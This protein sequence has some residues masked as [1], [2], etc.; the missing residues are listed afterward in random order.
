MEL[1]IQDYISSFGI[2][3]SRGK[4]C[5]PD[6]FFPFEEAGLE[7]WNYLDAISNFF[8]FN[9]EERYLRIAHVNKQGE[10]KSFKKIERPPIDR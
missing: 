8:P 5:S 10:V 1:K 9:F 6:L 4:A 7:F 2:W 3:F